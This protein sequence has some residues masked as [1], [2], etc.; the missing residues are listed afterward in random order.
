MATTFQSAKSIADALTAKNRRSTIFP[1]MEIEAEV[2]VDT[3]GYID[4]YTIC[5]KTDQIKTKRNWA[6]KELLYA[7]GHHITAI[8]SNAHKVIMEHIATLKPLPRKLK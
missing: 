2:R 8:E 5:V 3:D 4:F 7:G 6:G 1:A